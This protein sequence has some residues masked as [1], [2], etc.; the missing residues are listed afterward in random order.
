MSALPIFE[1]RR[2]T[3]HP[4]TFEGGSAVSLLSQPGMNL[5]H[6]N[7]S[8]SS[9]FAL[10]ADYLSVGTNDA[11]LLGLVRANYLVKR[12][13]GAGRQGNLY[14]LS[15]AGGGQWTAASGERERRPGWAWMY[16]LQADYET[17]Q[18]YT[19]FMARW[20]GDHQ[21]GWERA[22]LHALYRFGVA[23]Y[24]ARS[25]A[26]QAW[27][28]AQLSYHREMDEL[29]NLTLLMRL[30]MRTALWEVGADTQ[31]RP[32]LHLMAHF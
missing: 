16:G 7:Y 23:P 8:L 6:A 13:L 32:W 14:L 12:W 24:V 17:R 4:V 11:T 1:S 10:G 27:F 9:S 30:F 31:G 22:P 28:V 19:A 3:A 20:L 26:L 25:N 15:G 5:W 18:M 21:G 2:A 29:P